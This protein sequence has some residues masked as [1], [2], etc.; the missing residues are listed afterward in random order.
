MVVSFTHTDEVDWI[1]PEVPP[2]DKK[3]EIT[4]VSIVG[5]RGGK[6]THENVYWDQA[7][8][9]LQVGLLNPENVPED[10]KAEGTLRLPVVGAEA[11]RQILDPR[12]SRYNALLPLD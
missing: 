11:A 9:L 8:V 5:V 3:V 4:M 7:S 1:L 6:L 2:T 10:M 12:K